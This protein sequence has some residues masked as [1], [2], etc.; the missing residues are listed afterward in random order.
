M[1]AF[2]TG[3][4]LYD[5]DTLSTSDIQTSYGPVSVQSGE[6][7][8]NEVVMLARH[9]KNHRFLPH[10]I[11][12]L[13]HFEALRQLD[14]TAVISCSVCGILN[15]DWELGK[16][17]LVNDIYYPDNRLGDGRTCSLF[18]TPGEA[19][20]GHLLASSL[21]KSSLASAIRPLLDNPE[22]GVYGH[23]NGP[24]FNTRTEINAL[25][26]AG[27]DLISQTCG[28]EAVL[29]N[30][31]ELPYA[32]VAFGVDYANGVHTEPTPVETLNQ[33]LEKGRNL[34]LQLMQD[35]TEPE[36]G[37]AFENFVYRFA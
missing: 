32:L 37:F 6:L 26:T 5:H 2:I 14:V 3:S 33:N 17:V 15:P 29:A 9:G 8:G 16:P 20:R 36:N 21:I 30:E 34:F 13:A 10:H 22:E 35:L 7:N 18:Q 23:V 25:Q 4:G 19:G 12:H 11:P 27:V 24:R 28:P 1:L 31:L